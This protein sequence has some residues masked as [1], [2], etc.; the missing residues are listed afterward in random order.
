MLRRR[1]H[2]PTRSLFLSALVLATAAGNLGCNPLI[3][4]KLLEDVYITNFRLR[5]PTGA[6]VHSTI[7]LTFPADENGDGHVLMASPRDVSMVWL[8]LNAAADPIERYPTV[9]DLQ[10]LIFPLEGVQKVDVGGLAKVPAPM[11]GDTDPHVVVA[12]KAPG[13]PENAR[14]VRFDLPEF[15]R[16]DDNEIDISNPD[17]D[18]SPVPNFGSGL[19]AINLDG[20]QD[21]PEYEIAVGSDEGVLVFDSVGAN[22]E[23]YLAAKAGLGAACMANETDCFHFTHCADVGLP[24]NMTQGMFMAGDAPAIVASNESGLT[25]ITDKA[26]PETNAVGAPVYE[27]AAMVWSA[28]DGSSPNYGSEL[29]VDDINDDGHDDL[30]VGDPGANRVYVHLGST[31]TLTQTPTLTLE[32]PAGEDALAYG[33]ALGRA[34]LGQTIGSVLLVGAPSSTVGGQAE[35][36]KVFVYALGDLSAP[37]VVLAD[38]TPTKNTRYGEW[39]GGVRVDPDRDELLVSGENE[40]KVYVAISEEDPYAK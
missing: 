22:L 36:G 15:R 20:P 9:E 12:L 34:D 24:S 14:V 1:P 17:I 16:T 31:G 5:S 13:E 3:Y 19:A 7:A 27:C 10:A 37:I 28:P 11:P 32:P 29:F 26:S 33:F 38:E 21:E 40:A 35:V 4:D 18:G 39:V 6:S 2:S 25:F 8:N 23:T 30:L